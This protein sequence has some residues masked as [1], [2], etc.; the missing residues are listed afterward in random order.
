MILA[1]PQKVDL[2]TMTVEQLWSSGYRF[3]A[4]IDLRDHQPGIVGVDEHAYGDTLAS[5][6]HFSFLVFNYSLQCSYCVLQLLHRVMGIHTY[7]EKT[8]MANM[9]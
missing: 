3:F 2:A 6:N 7:I 1:S 5:V 4:F 8:R 9:K